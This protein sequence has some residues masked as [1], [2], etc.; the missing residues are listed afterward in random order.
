VERHRI[1]AEGRNRKREDTDMDIDTGTKQRNRML[2]CPLT[3]RLSDRDRARVGDA[4]WRQ[5]IST[6][7]LMRRIVA[8]GIEAEERKAAATAI[9]TAD[10]AAVREQPP[11]PTDGVLSRGA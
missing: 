7:E 2:R 9:Q 4:A 11:A 6:S 3:V 5:R 8:R 10:G 1:A